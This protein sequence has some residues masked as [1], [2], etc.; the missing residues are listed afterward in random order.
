[1]TTTRPNLATLLDAYPFPDHLPS[2]R[3]WVRANFATTTN[4]VIKMSGVSKHVSGPP[5]RVVFNFLR[6]RSDAIIVGLGT[7]KAESYGIPRADSATGRSPRLIVVTNSLDIEDTSRF[8]D[9]QTKPLI[10][11]S[12]HT[13]E[14]KSQRIRQI[15]ERSDVAAFGEESVDFKSL[16]AHLRENGINLLLCEGGPT[17]FSELAKE[18]L[19]DELCLTISPRIGSGPP[20]GFANIGSNP[21]IEMT[22]ASYFETDGFLFCRYLFSSAH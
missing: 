5:D 18:N 10:V 19:I 21:P 16:F 14:V 20:T 9:G 4:G 13:A 11:T 15:K 17:I 6:S 2:M 3:P 7:A 1:M 8:L 22:L 12:S